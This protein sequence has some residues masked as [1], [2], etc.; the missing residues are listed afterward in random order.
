[1]GLTSRRVWESM[2]RGYDMTY[3]K[4]KRETVLGSMGKTRRAPS[5]PSITNAF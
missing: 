2:E 3:R 4:R 1:M 5:A